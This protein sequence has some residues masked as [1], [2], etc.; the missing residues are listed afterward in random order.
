MYILWFYNL[1][2]NFNRIWIVSYYIFFNVPFTFQVTNIV[3]GRYVFRLKVTDD[4]G[5]S[6]EDTVSV[7]VKPG[8][9]NLW[10]LI[11]IIII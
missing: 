2:V 3:E 1:F 4:Q 6:S 11:N 5:A 10:L 8:I 9:I 7:N